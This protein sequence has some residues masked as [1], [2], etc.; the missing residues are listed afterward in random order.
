MH[1]NAH[2]SRRR[3]SLLLQR[4]VLLREKSNALF[5]QCDRL[6]QPLWRPGRGEHCASAPRRAP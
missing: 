1:F 5:Q 6:A 2:A 4:V 3:Q